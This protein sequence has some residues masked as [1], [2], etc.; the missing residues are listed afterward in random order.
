MPKIIEDPTPKVI[1]IA[2]EILYDQQKGLNALNMRD[3]AKQCGI[4]LG[5]FYNYIPDKETLIRY[6]MVDYW[7]EFLIIVD[8]LLSSNAHFY[9]TIE[10]LY[11]KFRDFVQFFHEIFIVSQST[12]KYVHEEE[13]MSTRSIYMVRFKEQITAYI[14]AYSKNPDKFS[15]EEITEFMLSNFMAMSYYS[16]Y[17]YTSFEKILK[18]LI[19]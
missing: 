10:Q 16:P 17:T 2:K 3:I 14:A 9:E 13:E 5:T 8:Q 12:T 15:P 4:G 18:N 11:F 7:D 1:S 19:E 6:L